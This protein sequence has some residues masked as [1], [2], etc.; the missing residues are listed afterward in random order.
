M[1]G[2]E[3]TLSELLQEQTRA[4]ERLIK[5]AQRIHAEMTSGLSKIQHAGDQSAPNKKR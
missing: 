2:S 4:L 1:S 5:E 3:P